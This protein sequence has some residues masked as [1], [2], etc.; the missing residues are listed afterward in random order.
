MVIASTLVISSRVHVI[1]PGW[2]A[3]LNYCGEAYGL[4]LYFGW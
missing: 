1:A 4:G 2:F 3:L